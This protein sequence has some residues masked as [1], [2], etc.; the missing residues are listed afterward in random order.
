MATGDAVGMSGWRRARGLLGKIGRWTLVVVVLLF[1]FIGF[2]HVTRGTVVRHVDDVG[3]DGNPLHPSEPQF[4]LSVA[5]LTGTSL[6]PGNTVEIM[7]DGDGTYPRLWDDL[8]SARQ[9]ITLQLYYGRVGTVSETLR[10]V[11]LDRARAGVKIYLLYDAFGGSAIPAARFEALREAGI[12]VAA[13]RP[14]QL[15]T[16]HL[17]QHR[18]HARGIIVDGHVAWTGGFG[19]DDKWL[20]DGRTNGSWRETNVRFE[21]PAVRQLQAAFAASWAEATGDLLTGRT[22]V[23]EPE[24]GGTMAGLLYAVPTMGSTTAERFLAM[25]IAGAQR[26]L[27]ITN[28]YFAPDQAFVNLLSAAAR[29][30]VDV[31]VL[32]AGENTDVPVVRYAG[33]AWYGP[34]LAAGVRLYE[35]QPTTMHAKTFVVDG[36]WSTIGSMNFDNRSLALNDETNLMVLD[37]AIGSQMDQLFMDDLRHS[38]EVTAE[39]FARRGIL[40]RINE[41]LSLLLHPVL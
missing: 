9:S 36:L 21:G 40:E 15:S 41:R 26:T 19:V 2:L 30:G 20:G 18:S 24:Q 32:S 8:R 13:F 7:L 1:A 10:D 12:A 5:M 37:P 31:R 27:Y 25:S 38:V 23:A 6:S 29:R 22:A 35:W 34:L 16:V 33:R 14:I 4:P 17:V 3:A 28:A 11:L 39:D